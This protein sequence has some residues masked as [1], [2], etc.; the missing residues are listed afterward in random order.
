MTA[1][2]ERYDVIVV[3]GGQ[4]GLALGYFLRA[5]GPPLRDPRGGRRAGRGVAGSGGT[6]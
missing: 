6:R 1:A 3:G 5:A 2:G 4:A